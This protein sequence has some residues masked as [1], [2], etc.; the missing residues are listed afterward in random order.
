[1]RARAML[2]RKYWIC[3]CRLPWHWKIE[4]RAG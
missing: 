4:K 2:Q 1:M 3:F